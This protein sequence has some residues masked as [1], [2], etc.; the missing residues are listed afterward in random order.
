MSDERRDERI[1]RGRDSL[2]QMQRLIDRHTSKPE[3]PRPPRTR[4]DNWNASGTSGG[5]VRGAT[6]TPSATP[7]K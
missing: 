6:K 5:V 4:G 7:K 3:K 2:Q 1:E